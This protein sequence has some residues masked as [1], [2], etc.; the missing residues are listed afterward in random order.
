VECPGPTEVTWAKT[1]LNPTRC[2]ARLIEDPRGSAGHLGSRAAG[3]CQQQDPLGIGTMEHKMCD[4]VSKRLR[5]ARTSA[6]YDQQRPGWSVI[7]NPVFNR[8]PLAFVQ[9]HRAIGRSVDPS[10][11]SI[12]FFSQ[13]LPVIAESKSH[14]P[15]SDVAPW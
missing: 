10:L 13:D 12:I 4:T 15:S 1:F 3:E 7:P 9:V 6:R 8:G 11:Q 14:L 5:F 2:A